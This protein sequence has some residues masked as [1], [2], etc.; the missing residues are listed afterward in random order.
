MPF[1]C[2][3]LILNRAVMFVIIQIHLKYCDMNH[4]S[5]NCNVVLK[6]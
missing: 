6:L 4:S 1:N 3:M 2:Y 5:S